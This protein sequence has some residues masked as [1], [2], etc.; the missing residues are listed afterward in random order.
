MRPVDRL[1]ALHGPAPAG[2][3]AVSA[4][5]AAAWPRAV[6]IALLAASL[7]VASLT[8]AAASAAEINTPRG[9]GPALMACWKPPHGTEG[10]SATARFSFR[11]DGSL[12]GPPRITFARLGESDKR[13]RAFLNSIADAFNACTPLQFTS[14][15]GRAVAGRIFTMRFVPSAQ[16]A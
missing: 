7:G 8:T 3:R 15:F 2:S 10:L 11:R 9:I 1:S 6:R 16:R 13:A 12:M 4:S 5:P 14:S